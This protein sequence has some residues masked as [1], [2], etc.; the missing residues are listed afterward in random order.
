MAIGGSRQNIL[1]IETH[2]TNQIYCF[3]RQENIASYPVS[4][5]I[6]KSSPIKSKIEAVSRQLIES[7]LFVKWAR[8]SRKRDTLRV[9]KEFEGISL[10]HFDFPLLL[11]CGIGLFVAFSSF[12]W[13]QITFHMMMKSTKTRFWS[14]L[15][16]FFDSRRHFLKD[17]PEK[18][19]GH[20]EF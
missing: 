5:I 7:G 15:N 2:L 12:I 14:R 19:Q 18:L 4:L 20:P 11:I 3:D 8:D 9:P 6:K 17:L 13:E 16:T 1:S 10:K